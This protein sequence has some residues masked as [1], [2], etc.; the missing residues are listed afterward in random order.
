MELLVSEEEIAKR[1]EKGILPPKPLEGYLKRYAK[2]V[3]SASTG[4]VFED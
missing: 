4:A 1:K 2:I 3:R